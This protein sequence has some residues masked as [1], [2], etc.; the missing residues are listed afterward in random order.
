MQ[1]LRDVSEMSCGTTAIMQMRLQQDSWNS[2][3]IVRITATSK[4]L[5]VIFPGGNVFKFWALEEN[6]FRST[7]L[8]KRIETSPLLTFFVSGVPKAHA[9]AAS[10]QGQ[11]REK[12]KLVSPVKFKVSTSGRVLQATSPFRATK[13]KHPPSLPCFCFPCCTT[14]ATPD[15]VF[16]P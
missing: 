16:N 12:L 15:R 3:R 13:N 14:E 11:S 2:S 8:R 10:G 4:F 7:S 6:H 9:F 5:D 1:Y